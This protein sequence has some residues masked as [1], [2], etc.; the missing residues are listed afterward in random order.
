MFGTASVFGCS[1]S[2]TA[3][4]PAAD[5]AAVADAGALATDAAV[6]V[7]AAPSDAAAPGTD[8]A[9]ATDAAPGDAGA[10]ETD[11]G[12]RCTAAAAD[13]GTTE[14][15]TL[16]ARNISCAFRSNA[17]QWTAAA[18]Y[19]ASLGSNWRLASKGVALKIA[20]SPEVCRIAVPAQWL[21][22]TST[23]AGGNLAWVVDSNGSSSTSST[24]GGTIGVGIL[25]VRNP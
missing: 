25:C 9:V 11:A 1:E 10:P 17:V 3:A 5:A 6:A 23:C 12:A 24:T 19:C 8:A 18:S 20:A 4:G 13:D 2:G 7:D 21:S 14:A 16:A 22:W 15:A